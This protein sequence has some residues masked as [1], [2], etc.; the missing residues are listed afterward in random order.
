MKNHITQHFIYE[1]T[2]TCF[3]ISAG[4]FHS[5]AWTSPPACPH[6]EH[7]VLGLPPMVPEKF[8]HL[9]SLTDVSIP[10]MRDRLQQLYHTSDLVSQSW[11]LLPE[12]PSVPKLKPGLASSSLRELLVP[13]VYNLPLVQ[14]LQ[15]T[16]AMGRNYGPQVGDD[17]YTKYKS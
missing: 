7:P 13:K 16:M 8:T 6:S 1:K 2:T 10:T 11:R 15:R 3:Q 9:R 4:S 12:S 17:V 14:I 5:A